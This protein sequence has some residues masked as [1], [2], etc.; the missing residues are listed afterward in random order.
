MKWAKHLHHLEHGHAGYRE[1]HR[2]HQPGESA[3]LAVSSTLQQTAVKDGQ[4][5]VRDIMKMT[6]SSDHRIID[7][8]TPPDSRT[9]LNKTRGDITVEIFGVVVIA[10]GREGTRLPFE[11]R[12]W[13]LPWPW[14]SENTWAAPA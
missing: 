13:E 1:L 9:Q 6:L 14:W 7:G 4:I 8:A 3:I 2:D 11:P 10:A 12:N 5:V